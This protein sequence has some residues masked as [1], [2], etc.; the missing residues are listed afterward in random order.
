MC[1]LA[2]NPNNH[3]CSFHH[4][5]SDNPSAFYHDILDSIGLQR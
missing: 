3:R 5:A 2:V 1:M 4:S